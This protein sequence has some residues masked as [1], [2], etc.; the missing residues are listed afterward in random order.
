MQ[1]L[2]SVAAPIADRVDRLL[3]N[4]KPASNKSVRKPA[5][6]G[7][8]TAYL[9]ALEYTGIELIVVEVVER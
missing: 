1:V 3:V 8:L 9:H 5:V 6:L 7:F 4:C 2:R